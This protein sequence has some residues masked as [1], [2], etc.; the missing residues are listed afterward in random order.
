MRIL[1]TS[2]PTQEPIDPVRFISNC[3]SGKMGRALAASG[4]AGG[5]DIRLISGPVHIELPQ[6]NLVIR[7]M[8]AEEML[9]AVQDN[10][11]WCDALIM[12]AAVSDWRPRTVSAHKIKKNEMSAE[13]LLERT[14]DILN[15]VQEKKASRIYVGFAAETEN[16]ISEARRKLLEKN[17]DMIVANDVTRPDSGFEVDTN[18]VTLLTNNGKIEEL[19]V[20]S[21]GAIANI[22]IE[23]LE[24]A[25]NNRS[26]F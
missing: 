22:I 16:I 4:I 17:L 25:F 18:K 6:E 13:L 19:P 9:Q 5:H 1:I 11:E 26:S 2:G 21:K 23:R 24:S 3:S 10:I 12:A 7:I 8:T 14:P 15:A 20:M